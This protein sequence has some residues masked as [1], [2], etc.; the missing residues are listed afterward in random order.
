MIWTID[1]DGFHA[2]VAERVLDRRSIDRTAWMRWI[3]DIE[4][5]ADDPASEY[6]RI[7]APEDDDEAHWLDDPEYPP[8][9]IELY[10]AS[11]APFLTPVS[12]PTDFIQPTVCV[13]ALT[14]LRWPPID[15]RIALAGHPI[16]SLGAR[17]G[18]K[19]LTR[20]MTQRIDNATAAALGGWLPVADVAVVADGLREGADQ[21]SD[22]D[23]ALWNRIDW[24]VP[25]HGS[26]EN[27]LMALIK[28]LETR[29]EALTRAGELGLPLRLT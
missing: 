11:M 24:A 9:T 7:W 19:R 3:R 27:A 29:A 8:Y 6:L 26:R 1:V 16:R 18:H 15:V 22:P 28:T 10:A 17:L 2:A 12:K 25:D 4:A 14:F 20:E 23:P 5:E 21:L 13:E